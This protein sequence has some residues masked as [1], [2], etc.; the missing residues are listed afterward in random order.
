MADVDQLL[1]DETNSSPETSE[2]TGLRTPISRRTVIGGAIGIGALAGLSGWFG[3]D[4]FKALSPAQAAPQG[5]TKLFTACHQCDQQ[6]GVVA[7]VR[8]GVL[9]KLD[10]HPLDPKA[11]GH[12]CPKGQGGIMDLYNPY[13]LKRPLVRTNP[14]KA[15]GV[16]PGWKEVTWDEVQTLVSG[17]IK[18]ILDSDGA[19]AFAGDDANLM[20]NFLKA[21]GSPN[22]FR[23]GNTCFYAVYGPM[24]TL[25]GAN[26]AHADLQPGV[27]K[28]VLLLSDTVGTVEQPLA[29]QVAE[30]KAA[31]AKLAVMDPRVSESAAMADVWMPVKPGTDLAPLLAFI[32]VLVTENL[33]DHAYVEANTV[34]IEHLP[35]WV[36]PYT[37]EWAAPIC[38][39]D[40]DTLRQVGRDLGRY[41]QSVVIMRRG[42]AKE[43][44]HYY[45]VTHA[46]A[47]LNALIGA[48]DV[49]GGTI[50]DRSAGLPAAK[51]KA[52]F[53][54]VTE[55]RYIDSR[56]KILPT[57]GGVY[58]SV[59]KN[60]GI[61]TAFVDA[62]K[63]GPYPIKFL[64]CAGA[65]WLHS[66]PNTALW[67]EI[68]KDKFL[69]VI[70]YQMTD[71]AWLADVVLPCPTYL[72][73]D[74]IFGATNYAPI[75]LVM[76]RQ[77]VVQ[78]MYDT[79][80]EAEIFEL[81]LE[82]LGLADSLPPESEEAFN[83]QL[84]GFGLTFDQLKEVG[85]RYIEGG[86]AVATAKRPG[87]TTTF[88]TPSGKI[89]LYS[90]LFEEA[91]FDPLPSWP[92][93]GEILPME[94]TPEYPTYFV[95]FNQARG[96]MS[97]HTW[98]AWLVDPE[99]EF[100][101]I[102]NSLA[103]S[104]GVKDGDTV[105]VTSPYGSM[106]VRA[107]RTETVRPD[108]VAML[109]GRGSRNTWTSPQARV[110]T[111]DNDISRPDTV[112]EMV[113]LYTDKIEP[114]GNPRFRDFTV[115]VEKV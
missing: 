13:R 60:A 102:H 55:K 81:L 105:R 100:L 104:I 98:N 34:G 10:G 101:W 86:K 113:G 47:I 74:E 48:I 28:Y 80:T 91:G 23:C 39:V 69:M 109:H 71:T 1:S 12:L 36:K 63:N 95:S 88:S 46:W 5:V 94:P 22:T 85:F 68:V 99:D 20:A 24:M 65:N 78:R 8:D 92:T 62:M 97:Q 11:K 31:G 21:I 35:E 2:P 106:T 76:A 59:I 75:P 18:E 41:K 54:A 58:D 3:P 9:T 53:P 15:F 107:K 43:R 37:P 27:T 112:A 103:D 17:K 93:T 90:S 50:R 72:E 44:L 77:A 79:K 25:T 115:K 4:M 33:Y 67:E 45:R 82:P 57:P 96:F 89:E 14:E 73:R 110:G 114:L 51:A 64:L 42:A 83:E 29:R 19:R 56:E 7:T 26:F 38:G 84:A 111:N 49:P 61:Q 6:C 52:A 16:D 70:D 66:S 87:P 108:T 40:A 32:N 30:V